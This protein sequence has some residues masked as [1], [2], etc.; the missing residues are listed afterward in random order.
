MDM[1][2]ILAPPLA[3]LLSVGFALLIYGFGALVGAK[4]KPSAGKLEPYACGESFSAEKFRFGY[5]VF[6]VAAIFFTIMH[7]AVLTIATVPSGALAYRA[8]AYLIVIAASIA[9]L[10]S[11]ID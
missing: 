7:V 1:S 2:V 8:L 10:Y 11:N 4:A 3:F 5:R 6:F 9:I